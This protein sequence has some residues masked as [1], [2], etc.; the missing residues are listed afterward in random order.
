MHQ[1]HIGKQLTN[2]VGTHSRRETGRS[3]FGFRGSVLFFGQ[4]LLLFKLR[5][6]RIGY[7]V[8]LEVNHLFQ[9]TGFHVQ[10]ISKTARHRLEEPD[11]NDRGG[12]L[13]MPHSLPP[14]A[15][16]SHLHA[17]AI[18]DHSLVFH[19]AIFTARAFPVLLR[20]KNSFAKQSVL[21]WSIGTIVDRL[22]L[23]DFAHRPAA[24]IV[25]SSQ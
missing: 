1:I 17:T 6:T 14:H 15:T 9:T 18:A 2:R 3:K 13:D 7:H 21:L 10:Q 25:R 20:T 23:L 19:S 5:C 4:Q 11:V 22:G 12:K 24:N 16:V 8:V